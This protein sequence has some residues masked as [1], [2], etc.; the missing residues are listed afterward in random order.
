M[1]GGD[2]LACIP[3]SAP[4]NLALFGTPWDLLSQLMLIY[5]QLLNF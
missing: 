2:F 4:W 5:L 3:A 1:C